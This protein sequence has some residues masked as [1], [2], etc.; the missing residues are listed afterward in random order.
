MIHARLHGETFGL[1]CGE[2][3]MEN[4]PIITYG[5]SSER[6]HIEILGDHGIYYNNSEELRDILTNFQKYIK[7]DNYAYPYLGYSPDIIMDKFNNVFLK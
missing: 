6:S 4:K 5:L 7:Y 3:A 1:A 2:F